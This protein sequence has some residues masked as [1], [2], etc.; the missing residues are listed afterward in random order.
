MTSQTQ[1]NA[2]AFAKHSSKTVSGTTGSLSDPSLSS[3]FVLTCPHDKY[4]YN[5]DELPCPQ[6]RG[7]AHFLHRHFVCGKQEITCLSSVLRTSDVRMDF[8]Y[9]KQ[10]NV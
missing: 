4:H 2:P 10:L 6:L 5:D 9:R 3:R 7:L 8:K 1:T